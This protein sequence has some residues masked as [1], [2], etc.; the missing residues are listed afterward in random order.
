[1]ISISSNIESLIPYQPGRSVEEIR[2]LY[3]LEHIVKLASNEN[4]L[5]PAPKALLAAEEALLNMHLYPR[6]GVRLRE[7]LAAI[8]GVAT[9]NVM[10]GA[11]SES[12]LLSLIRAY[13]TR[14]DEVL[15]AEGTFIAIY[16]QTKSQGVGLR[17]VPL[18]QYRFDL[19]A[20]ADAITDKTKLIY[21]ANPNNPT[22]TIFTRAEFEKFIERV[23]KHILV[24]FDEAYFDYAKENPDYPNSLEYRLDNV[25]TLRT[26]SKS[27]GLAGAR[28]GYGFAHPEI[29]RNVRKVHLPFDPSLLAEAAGVGALDDAEF[30]ERTIQVNRAG[31]AF[32]EECFKEI[33]LPVVPTEANFFMAA[34]G[35]E[36]EAINFT[37]DLLKQGV[38]V[39]YLK[40]F[41]LPN[42][43][44]ITIGIQEENEFLMEAMRKVYSP[45]TV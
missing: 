19:D 8:H 20:L 41:R 43:V 18:K 14:D 5:G 27:Y 30:L 36:A 28:I 4:P 9:D 40:A 44:R 32:L 7:K 6:T 1:M 23:P 22:G 3:G 11:G 10:V 45:V 34:F 2:E 15:T 24:V 17:T 12:V 35:T 42:C 16:V 25:V 21:F 29:C 37:E 31:K 33:G 38:I 26:F 39:R 13:L